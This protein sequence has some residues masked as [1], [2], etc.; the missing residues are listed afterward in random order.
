MYDPSIKGVSYRSSRLH[1]EDNNSR[2]E[3][4]DH[5]KKA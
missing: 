4:N 2:I 5:M 3:N 1:Q